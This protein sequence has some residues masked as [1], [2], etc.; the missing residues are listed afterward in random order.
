MFKV[1]LAISTLLALT[2]CQT[3]GSTPAAGR[4]GEPKTDYANKPIVLQTSGK[5]LMR[6]VS[7]DRWV[8]IRN[9]TKNEYTRLYADLGAGEWAAATIDSRN[10]LQNHPSDEVALTV[11]SLALTMRQNYSLAGYYAKLLD[12]YHPGNP[13]VKNILGLAE[14]AKP[15]ATLEDYQTSIRLFEEAFNA[16]PNQIASGLNLAQLHLEMGNLEGARDVYHAVYSRCDKCSEAGLGYGIAQARL[17]SYAKAEE[18]FNDVLSEDKHNA[19][20][21]YYLALVAKYGKNDNQEAIDQLSKMLADTESKNVEMQRKANFLLRRI[22]AQ[23]YGSP[24]DKAGAQRPVTKKTAKPISDVKA[25]E[26]EKAL[27]GNGGSD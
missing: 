22:Q 10:Y 24:K 27:G 21:R 13:E 5:T 12:K 19:Y 20:A 6:Q 3:T 23:V 1:I 26:I 8:Q 25:D 15:G 14:M 7:R 18:A 11:L 9:S 16:A 4:A 2:A 17:Q